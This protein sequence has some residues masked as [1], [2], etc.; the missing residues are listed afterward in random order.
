MPEVDGLR[1]LFSGWTI[2]KIEHQ[3]A[4]DL[5]YVIF[6]QNAPTVAHLHFEK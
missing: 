3:I 1:D 5:L 4:L 6:A 2:F